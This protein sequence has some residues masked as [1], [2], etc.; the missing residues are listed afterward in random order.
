MRPVPPS[1]HN[2]RVQQGILV[3]F[4]RL[5]REPE[6]DARGV[7]IRGPGD[8]QARAGAGDGLHPPGR[9]GQEAQDRGDRPIFHHG[10]QVRA[11]L[12]PGGEARDPRQGAHRV[13]GD[14]HGGRC[15]GDRR[16]ERREVHRRNDGALPDRRGQARDLQGPIRRSLLFF[17][18]IF[19]TSRTMLRSFRCIM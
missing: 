15:G 6:E 3:P 2:R 8:R 13:Q 11:H 18:S 1:P 14:L 17:P 19:S 12:G 5:H 4:L 10:L 16:Q 7:R 9:E